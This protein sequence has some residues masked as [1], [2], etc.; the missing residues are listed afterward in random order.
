M[1]E[2]RDLRVSLF[3]QENVIYS[4]K[5]GQLA[6]EVQRDIRDHS[7]FDISHFRKTDRVFVYLD[8]FPLYLPY[9]LG[10]LAGNPRCDTFGHT[11]DNLIIL[12]IFPIFRV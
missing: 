6:H 11:S 10:V 8:K 3:L 1:V 9:L 12:H 7:V 4:E 2:W 5:C